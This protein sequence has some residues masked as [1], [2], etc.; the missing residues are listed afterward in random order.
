[1]ARWGLRPTETTPMLSDSPRLVTTGGGETPG[2]AN[3]EGTGNGVNCG[4]T[5]TIT[6]SSPSADSNN[7]LQHSD[8][9]N[10]RKHR[11]VQRLLSWNQFSSQEMEALYQRYVYRIQLSALAC[12]L[13]LLTILCLSL[14][15]LTTVF[16][17]GGYTFQSLY[18]YLQGVIFIAFFVCLKAGLMREQHFT[19]VNYSVL[20]FICVLAV[21]S[22]PF[23]QLLANHLAWGKR[24]LVNVNNENPEGKN[25]RFMGSGTTWSTDVITGNN[26]TGSYSALTGSVN[27]V[28]GYQIHD[29]DGS[30]SL[31]NQMSSTRVSNAADG[32]WVIAFVV[33]NV[34]ALMPFRTLA[35][36]LVGGFLSGLHLVVASQTCSDIPGRPYGFLWRQEFISVQRARLIPRLKLTRSY[37]ALIPLDWSQF[38]GSSDSLY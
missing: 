36:C 5:T 19:T 14:A 24:E 31:Q 34:Y 7:H 3:H 13:L 28:N 11:G 25:V 21:F 26:V 10:C 38:P 35:K 27:G 6:A 1:M 17:E 22:A 37:T 9:N 29:G 33:F 30:E 2:A 15:I 8:N 4:V 20:T 23:P 18:L 16:V 12:L 32:A